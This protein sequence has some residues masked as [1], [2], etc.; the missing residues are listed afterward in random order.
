MDRIEQLMKN[1]KPHVPEPGTSP[2]AFPDRSDVFSTDPNLVRP[3]QHR[4]KRTAV[5]ATAGGLLAAACVLG[6]VVLAGNLA[7]QSAPAPAPAATST[8]TASA[9]PS[10]TPTL[11]PSATPTPTPISTASATPTPISTGTDSPSIADSCSITNIDQQRH[12]Q[13]RAIEPIPAQF[14]QYYT[15]L[16]CA[17]GWIA[18]SITDEGV[19]ARGTDGGNAWFSLARLQDNGRYLT[20]FSQ[21]WASVKSWEFQSLEVQ[22]GEYATAQE[23]MDQEFMSNGIPVQLR[24]ELV[25]A[26]PT[27]PAGGAVAE[28]PV[29]D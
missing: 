2:N 27:G 18:Y 16:G 19:R 20:D 13:V 8:P 17:E 25:G 21:I 23:A 28:Q 22:H 6:A 5:R 4:P 1:A 24:P 29:S 11:S 14:Q 26:G 7:P 12:D 10:S 3:A 15:V 9:E